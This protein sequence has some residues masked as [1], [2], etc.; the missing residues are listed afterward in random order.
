MRTLVQITCV[1]IACLASL[2]AGVFITR[3]HPA[4]LPVLDALLHQGAA[5][6]IGAGLVTSISGTLCCVLIT[7]ARGRADGRDNGGRPARRP[8]RVMRLLHRWVPAPVVPRLP[9][10][11][12]LVSRM[13]GWPQGVLM[14]TGVALAACLAYRLQPL[15]GPTGT[16]TLA[17]IAALMLLPAFLIIVC[18][19]MVADLAPDRLPEAS[20]LAALLRLPVAVLL[21]L[22]VLAALRGF[23]V[24]LPAAMQRFLAIPVLAVDAELAVRALGPWF[25]PRPAPEKAR[26]V[27]GSLI[28]SLLQPEA[29]RR[30]NIASR[31]RDQFG[32]DVSRSW[33]IGYA[34]HAAPPVLLGLLLVAWGLSGVTRIGLAERGAYQRF[35]APVAMLHP[36]LHFIL[37]WPFGTVRPVEFGVVH[38]ASIGTDLSQ[39]KAPLDTSIADGTPPETANQLWD[40]QTTGDIAYLIASRSGTRQSFETAS[41]DMRVMYRIGMDDESARRVLY[42]QAD[43]DRLIRA[44]AGRLLSRFFA[45][46]T[47]DQV[48]GERRERIA[49]QL[50]TELQGELD[51]RHT[52]LEV[53][54]LEVESMHPPAGAAVAYRSVQAAQIIASTQRSEEIGRAFGALSAAARDARDTRDEAQSSATELVSAAQTDRVQND[55]DLLA[56][57]SGGP[58]FTLERYFATLRAALGRAAVE[59]VDDRLGKDQRP[60][61]DLRAPLPHDGGQ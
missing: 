33:A 13:A 60:L 44:L 12:S 59:I 37:P 21:V 36:G 29:L 39:G 26:A 27:V 1:Q 49:A 38:S 8:G 2:L 57:D 40:Q 20:R 19:R 45:D 25:L 56:Y 43:P 55:A 9:V 17:G 22:S 3:T 61:I 58:A 14:L 7:W 54:A 46:T 15:P 41:V 32:V 24:E 53:V 16:T 51:R 11:R 28:A 31:L 4:Q 10:P 18:E 35:G 52:G 30:A 48:L 34:R 6:L 50:Q 23:G 5:G 47:L 42:G